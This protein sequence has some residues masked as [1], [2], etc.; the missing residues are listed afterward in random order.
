MKDLLP[1][2]AVL[3]SMVML[4]L[5]GALLGLTPIA[6]LLRLPL[7]EP[8]WDTLRPDP[9]VTL[10]AMAISTLSLAVLGWLAWP[11]R[12]VRRAVETRAPAPLPRYTWFGVFSLLIAVV[13]VDGDAVNLA[14]GMITLALALFANADTQRRTGNSLI[15]QR[16]GYFYSLFPASLAIGWAF[17]WLNLFLQLWSY[18]G[19]TETMAFVLGQSVHYAA[20]LPALLSLRQWLAS[21]PR[22][23]SWTSRARP[24]Q[25]RGSRGEGVVLI[26]I[27][28]IGLVGASIWPDW[29]FPLALLAPLLLALGLQLLRGRPTLFAGLA[30][31]DW[32]RILLPGLSA[33]L[34]SALTHS[35]NQLFGPGWVFQLPLIGGPTLL[36]LPVPAWL[37]TLPLGLFGVW[38][39]DQLTTPWKARP[40]QPRYRPRF[41]VKIPLVD[42]TGKNKH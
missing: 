19:A 35:F 5:A 12:P 36:G 17:Y 41:P 34:L 37:W 39:G 32:S 29:I 20:L 14:C 38:I 6:E 31:G 16:P 21:F 33:L 13:A 1:L 3:G 28:A 2:L 23:S 4:P 24:T 22:L 10:A 26:G 7:S 30:E 27:G 11:R 25:G 15:R 18:P 8:A 9:T 42:L 40:Q